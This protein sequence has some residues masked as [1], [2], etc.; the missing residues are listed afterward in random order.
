[1]DIFILNLNKFRIFGYIWDVIILFLSV[2]FE[3]VFVPISLAYFLIVVHFF[4]TI[5]SHW[6]L[7][8]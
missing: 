1:M 2:H 7:K 6:D 4:I 5:Q 3:G 8:M